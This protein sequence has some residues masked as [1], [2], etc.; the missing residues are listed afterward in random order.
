[1][2][3][4]V[5]V[6]VVVEHRTEQPFPLKT[7]P[8]AKADCA[9]RAVQ[10]QTARL[11]VADCWD[12]KSVHSDLTDVV[13]C[14]RSLPMRSG[15]TA[16]PRGTAMRMRTRAAHEKIG[17]T[18]PVPVA[19]LAKHHQSLTDTDEAE[20]ADSSQAI[21]RESEIAGTAGS[22]VTNASQGRWEETWRRLESL[23]QEEHCQTERERRRREDERRDAR[24]RLPE[25]DDQRPIQAWTISTCYSRGGEPGF[26]SV[27]AAGRG[28]KKARRAE[29]H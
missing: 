3:V 29:E 14:K 24:H 18:W 2:M 15:E 8:V 20:G 21:S 7:A 10:T 12:E 19:M 17:Q 4:V 25:E 23:T 27:A 5:V 26:R 28:R 6:V 13:R 1:M 22:Q 9:P 16:F 11:A